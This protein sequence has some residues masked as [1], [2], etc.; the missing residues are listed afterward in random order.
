MSQLHTRSRGTEDKAA[1]M[2]C[3]MQKK[4]QSLFSSTSGQDGAR[5]AK[6]SHPISLYREEGFPPR[7]IASGLCQIL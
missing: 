3:A 2:I 6:I 7:S 1:S 4:E 5:E